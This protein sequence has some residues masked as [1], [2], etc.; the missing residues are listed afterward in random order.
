VVLIHGSGPL[1]RLLDS[2]ARLVA[3]VLLAGAHDP[4]DALVAA[5][6]QRTRELLDS[7]GTPPEQAQAALATLDRA[8]ADLAAIRGGGDVSGEPILGASVAFWRSWID[9]AGTV[10]QLAT[11]L[12]QPLLVL[13]GDLDWNVGPDQAA[14]WEQTLASSSATPEVVVLPCITHALNCVTESDPAAIQPDDLGTHVAPDVI[15]TIL[16]FLADQT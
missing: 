12:T 6:A 10:P 4:P 14:A 15:D 13:G 5:Q 3:G 7:L 9:Q 2:D 1:S 8:A 11:G 16:A